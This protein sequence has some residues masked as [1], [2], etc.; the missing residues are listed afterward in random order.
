MPRPTPLSDELAPALARLSA[1]E[2]GFIRTMLRR[3]GPERARIGLASH[4]DLVL[5]M[6]LAGCAWLMTLALGGTLVALATTFVMPTASTAWWTGLAAGIGLSN[7]GVALAVWRFWSA[8]N[9]RHAA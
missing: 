6:M 2:R 4:G 1:L 3:V 5:T 8:A 9:P 7:A